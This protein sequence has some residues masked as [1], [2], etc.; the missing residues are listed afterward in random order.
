VEGLELR[1]RFPRVYRGMM[2][3][4]A[5]GLLLQLSI[6][7]NRYGE[8]V[9]LLAVFGFLTAGGIAACAAVLWWRREL[10]LQNLIFGILPFFYI[11]A[12]LLAVVINTGAIGYASAAYTLWQYS[13][14]LIM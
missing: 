2:V 7:L 3:S 14:M 13:M 9:Q 10:N 4:L 1:R 6:P 12:G 11:A 5:F 8:A